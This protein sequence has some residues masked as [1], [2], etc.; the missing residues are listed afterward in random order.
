VFV[1]VQ[2]LAQLVLAA[3]L[4][5]LVMAR[6]GVNGALT[7]LAV[8]SVLAALTALAGPNS[9]AALPKA[10]DTG[11]LDAR[12]L[13]GLAA[14]FLYMAFIVALWVY[15]EPLAAQAGLSSRE[16]GLAIALALGLQV[17]GG[18]AATVVGD[19]APPRGMLLGIGAI[20]AVILAV[21][22]SGPGRGL[23]IACVA[24][25]GFL[26]LFAL[27]FQTLLLIRIDPSRRA[28]MQLGAA[29]LLG[30]SAG[31]LAASL[32]VAEGPVKRAL[33]LSGACLV[34]ALALISLL[35]SR[36]RAA[37]GAGSTD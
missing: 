31:P 11:R 22:W 32:V 18:A 3:A 17:L 21:L 35:A 10:D 34:L 25:F 26:W 36:R 13:T 28:A 20:N 24:V 15:L 4:P 8:I 23:F 27:P 33:I 16:A 29:Q 7:C 14:V 19:R 1:T 12:S 37:S 30:S 6:W 9:F 5:V 2:T